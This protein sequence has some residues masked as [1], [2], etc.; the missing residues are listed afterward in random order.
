MSN[1]YLIK[2]TLVMS[3]SSVTFE[4]MQWSI[5]EMSFPLRRHFRP[6]EHHRHLQTEVQDC[7]VLEKCEMCTFSDQKSIAA[8]KE[9][10]RKQ[11]LE[12]M[13][14]DGDGN[15]SLRILCSQSTRKV[16]T[17]QL[18]PFRVEEC[19]GLLQ[20]QIHGSG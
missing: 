16:L 6:R 10:G 3:E 8:C 9:S 1:D 4:S 13:T 15:V 19:N 17:F 18:C 12:C 5:T 11:K 14:W 20:L 7:K 2:L